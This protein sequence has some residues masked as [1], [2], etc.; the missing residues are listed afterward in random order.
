MN[1]LLNDLWDN[2]LMELPMEKNEEKRLI[3][4][5]VMECEAYLD[6]NLSDEQKQKFHDFDNGLSE[7]TA[8]NEREAFVRGVRFAVRFILESQ[9]F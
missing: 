7:V 9:R 5:K 4:N 8:I 6:A 1:N 2:Y 3:L